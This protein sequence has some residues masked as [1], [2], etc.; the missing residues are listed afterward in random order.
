MRILR[1]VIIL[2]AALVGAGAVVGVAEAVTST[3]SVTGKAVSGVR[4][5]SQAGMIR[6]D[7]QAQTSNWVDIPGATATVTI[8][9]STNG[10]LLANFDAFS[11]CSAPGSGPPTCGWRITVNGQPMNPDN[12]SDAVMSAGSNGELRSI[13]RSSNVLAAGTYT[14]QAQALL[15]DPA[16]TAANPLFLTNWS[17]EVQQAKA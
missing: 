15:N 10:V 1:L 7:G 12:G 6:V 11:V 3:Q 14:V 16:Y 9:A 13:Q 8:P 5:V 4:F 2:A 17:L